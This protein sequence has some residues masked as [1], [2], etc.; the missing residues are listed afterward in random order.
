MGYGFNP[1]D[2]YCDAVTCKAEQSSYTCAA[3]KVPRA[4][5]VVVV[6]VDVPRLV[7]IEFN[8]ARGTHA[9]LLVH[10]R[11]QAFARHTVW[12][13]SFHEAI[14]RITPFNFAFCEDAF[15]VLLE[16]QCVIRLG[17][18]FSAMPPLYLTEARR[19]PFNL[20]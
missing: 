18:R 17:F 4:A 14:G 3:G 1:F 8:T 11:S 2:V 10:H 6:D 15:L 20:C 19:T 5:C 9:V 16:P 12:P 13:P 7:E